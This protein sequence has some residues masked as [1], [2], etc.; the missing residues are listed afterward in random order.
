M[1]IKEQKAG[2][3]SKE[4]STEFHSVTSNEQKMKDE[5]LSKNE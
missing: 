3:Y 4:F 5:N 2:K 1:K